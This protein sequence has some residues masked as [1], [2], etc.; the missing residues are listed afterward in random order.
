MQH[1]AGLDVS[2][3]KTSICVIDAKGLV[4]YENDVD[5][6]PDAIAI[7]L[8]P[9]AKTLAS[10][11]HEA[12]QFSHWLQR[13]LVQRKLPAQCLETRHARAALKAQRNKTDRADA[14]GI[15]QLMRSGWA[16]IVHVKSP[17]SMRLRVLIGQRRNLKRKFIDLSNGVRH[18]LK[19]FGVKLGA[20]SPGRFAKAVE[21]AVAGDPMLE[22]VMA[23]MLAARAALWVQM[24]ALHKLVAAYALKDEVCRRFMEIPGVGPVTAV[25]FKAAV[26]DPAR[27]DRSRT[28]GAHFGLTPRRWQSGDSVNHPGAMSRMGDGD[29]RSVLFEAAQGMLLRS[30][31]KTVLRR[32]ALALAR[33]AGQKKAIVALARKLA[34]VMHAMW[35]DG[36]HFEPG[37]AEA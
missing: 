15:A 14:L 2:V 26:D 20:V 35:R 7:A 13:E 22:A 8:K 6:D 18:T 31:A 28:V 3:A 4:L 27:F 10:V 21:A 25:A 36:T 9:W 30:K 12:G 29:M 33:R 23:A 5:T 37:A 34:V 16:K 11:G 1:F 24:S 32:W 19:S 17:Q